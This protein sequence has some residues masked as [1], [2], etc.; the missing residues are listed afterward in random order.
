MPLDIV[1]RERGDLARRDWLLCVK[2]ALIR[3]TAESNVILGNQMMGS[4]LTETTKT[5]CSNCQSTLRLK[6]GLIGKKV[7]CP[8]CEQAFIVTEIKDDGVVRENTSSAMEKSQ[9]NQ[10][11]ARKNTSENKPQPETS[12]AIETES[13][14]PLPSRLAPPAIQ[15]LLKCDD[16]GSQVSR[17]ASAC[18][19]CGAPVG[20]LNHQQSGDPPSVNA[21]DG[22][23]Q[24][25]RGFNKVVFAS[26]QRLKQMNSKQRI[27]IIVVGIAVVCLLVALAADPYSEIKRKAVVAAKLQLKN[28]STFK[29]DEVVVSKLDNKDRLSVVVKGTAQND[30]GATKDN[31]TWLTWSYQNK[32]FVD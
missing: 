28:P 17:R 23:G 13:P 25:Q 12:Q 16:C 6:A 29:L 2:V 31:I 3:L 5:Q 9:K 24:F 1:A 7:R 10:Q 21:N 22:L 4:P 18:P 19:N 15:K 11:E 26:K 14:P 30:F 8:K 27:S 32:G 20:G